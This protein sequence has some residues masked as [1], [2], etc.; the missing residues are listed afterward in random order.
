MSDSIEAL[1]LDRSIHIDGI[2]YSYY[3]KDAYHLIPH[4]IYVYDQLSQDSNN[5]GV[6]YRIL[7]MDAPGIIET[8]EI[9]SL[10]LTIDDDTAG[11]V[12]NAFLSFLTE[13]TRN[14]RVVFFNII[15]SYW[16]F[17]YLDDEESFEKYKITMK[18]LWQLYDSEGCDTPCVCCKCGKVFDWAVEFDA[19]GERSENFDYS[20]YYGFTV[21]AARN[22]QK[23]CDCLCE[24][25]DKEFNIK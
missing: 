23:C 15:H 16:G 2:A 11:K 10:S 4:L 25:C 19:A 5:R 20:L 12:L 6:I 18:Q 22:E 14:Q 24:E 9:Q 21:F 8:E 3:M 13:L 7:D 1:I 17:G